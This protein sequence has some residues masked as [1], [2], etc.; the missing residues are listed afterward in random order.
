[1]SGRSYLSSIYRFIQNRLKWL[2]WVLGYWG[3]KAVSR[4]QLPRI[5]DDVDW[6][7]LNELLEEYWGV[8]IEVQDK[9]WYA[10]DGKT[11]QGVAGQQKRVLLAVSHRE[12]RTVAQQP[13]HGPK[14][15]EI[16]VVRAMLAAT[17]LD[18]GKNTLDA[19]HFNP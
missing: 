9:A 4:S 13:M 16:T 18:K 2:R 5:L 1:M 11:L 10:L 14:E 8:R 12:R 6:A 7:A 15:S 17:G 19:L 3:A